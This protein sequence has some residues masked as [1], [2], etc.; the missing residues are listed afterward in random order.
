MPAQAT[1][2]TEEYSENQSDTSQQ[3][4]DWSDAG[5]L[6]EEEEEE[7][8]EEVEVDDDTAN[9]DTE[10]TADLVRSRKGWKFNS[11]LRAIYDRFK[12]DTNDGDTIDED[13]FGLRARVQADWGVAEGVHLGARLAALCFTGD[14]C[15]PD[16]VMDVASPATNGLEGGQL[17]MDELYLHWFRPRGSL[18][19]GRLQTRFVLRSGVYAKSLDRN[20]S[21]N[22][23]VTWTD[24]VQGMFRAQNGWN[25]SFILQRNASDGTG[26]IRHGQLNFDDRAARNTYFLG[27]ENLKS[28]GIIAQRGLDISYLP[29]SLLVDGTVDGNREDYWGVVSRL[30]VRWP[31]RSKGVRFR[32]GTEIGYAPNVPTA[33]GANLVDSADGLAWDV[34]ASIM[35][36]YPDH[37]IGLNYG[38][39]G[40][41]WLLS[42]QF[43]PN[44][45]LF[46]IRYQW[47][48]DWFPL[49]EVRFRWRKPL[50]QRVDVFQRG[51]VL[52]MYARLT[53]EFTLKERGT[54][55]SD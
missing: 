39:T 38:Q 4:P 54:N 24:G 34:V 46:E 31:N 50:E 45:E 23:N 7:E 10:T 16:W 36:F 19:I 17:T 26:S 6:D 52:D 47:R 27:F 48:P 28:W 53:W 18:A 12:A 30:A 43:L 29:S 37:S 35:D 15:D 40:A 33:E 3:V 8:E 5:T 41:G 14:N 25:S 49:V 11:D 42:P 32:G 2:H 21:N 9:V 22:V 13:A 51:T 55:W 44:E 20:D 1:Q